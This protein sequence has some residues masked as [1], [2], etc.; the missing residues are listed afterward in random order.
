[1]SWSRRDVL[2][3]DTRGTS[4]GASYR[5]ANALGPALTAVTIDIR[6]AVRNE[7]FLSNHFGFGFFIRAIA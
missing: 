7:E 3:Q 1:M 6:A 2:F 4:S 5:I